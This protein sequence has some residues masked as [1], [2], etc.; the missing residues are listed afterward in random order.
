MPDK[1][2][3]TGKLAWVAFAK[4]GEVHAASIRVVGEHG[5]LYVLEQSTQ[6]RGLAA[7]VDNDLLHWPKH[8]PTTEHAALVKFADEARLKRDRLEV[9]HSVERDNHLEAVHMISDNEQ[10]TIEKL[11]SVNGTIH[12]SEFMDWIWGG[13]HTIACWGHVKPDDFIEASS[14]KFISYGYDTDERCSVRSFYV[15]RDPAKDNQGETDDAWRECTKDER[16]ARPIT[17]EVV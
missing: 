1:R 17:V 7:L 4:N 12:P 2:I 13:E 5:D 16:G 8:W 10:A 9:R 14:E 15:C 3:K 11:R 6:N